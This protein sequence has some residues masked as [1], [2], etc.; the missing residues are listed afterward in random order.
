MISIFLARV[1]NLSVL[2]VS[3]AW[4]EAG[5]TVQMT[6][7]R[8]PLP[9]KELCRQSM[10]DDQSHAWVLAFL[11]ETTVLPHVSLFGASLQQACAGSVFCHA[12]RLLSGPR[13]L[14]EDTTTCV[15]SQG[16]L[17]V[18]DPAT[19]LRTRAPLLIATASYTAES[20][21][22]RASR[23]SKDMITL[24]GATVDR[25]LMMTKPLA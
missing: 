20:T 23:E 3:S 16:R 6:E 9:L 21:T 2:W 19:G 22:G 14:L 11:H 25:R 8:A 17:P 4:L 12:P 18:S 24:L 10:H 13:P 15:L 7:M 1:A 5:V